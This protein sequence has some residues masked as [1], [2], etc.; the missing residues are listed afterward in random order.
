MNHTQIRKYLDSAINSVSTCISNYVRSP[1]ID[2]S[3][4]RKLPASKLISFLIA[5]G[6]SSTKNELL[7]YFGLNMKAPS[8]SA[9]FQQREKLKPEALEKVFD[10]F[11]QMVSSSTNNHM[12]YRL[13]A[14]DGSTASFFSCDKYSPADKYF[15]SPGVSTKGA[16]SIHINAFQ[17][18][19]SHLY[20]DA[21]LQPV[22]NKDEF[23]A[24]CT[25]VDRHPVIPGTKNIYIGDRGYCSYN[26]MAHVEENGQHFLFRAKDID[27]KGLVGNFDFPN[28]DTFDITIN[29]SLV[30]SNSSKIDCG[31]DYRRF[32]DA[33]ASFDYLEYGSDNKYR[34]SFRVVRVMLSD[35]SYECLV[36]NLPSDE[37]PAS[38][39]KKLYYVRW[40][41]ESSFRKLKYTIGLS[42]FHSYKPEL[43]MQE[44]WARLIT[45]NF[46]EAMINST[47]VKKAKRK[48]SYKV[49]FSVA[50]H[51]CRVFL[52]YHSEENPIDVMALLARE[53][54]PIRDNRKYNRLQT[55]HFRK[56]RYFIYRAA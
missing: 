32:I 23:S 42:N 48:H 18:L 3:R 5:E 9:F 4:N 29:V 27:K 12:G 8:S 56:P 14:A 2:F 20:T 46:T 51:V 47:I 10:N 52:R 16:Y 15:I 36:T 6:S 7:D 49:N 17:D 28:E 44:I 25:I 1:G 54:I 30:R 50:A 43:I 40:G 31:N 39:L 38:R 45:Y 11:T 55:A 13:I 22:H 24:F 41:I 37:F 53:L 26:N 19:D 21:I 34:I 35:D 33:A